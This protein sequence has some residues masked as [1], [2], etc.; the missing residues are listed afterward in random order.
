MKRNK[1]NGN[2]I[3]ANAVPIH[4]TIYPSIHPSLIKL[5]IHNITRMIWNEERSIAVMFVVK[6]D[7]KQGYQEERKRKKVHIEKHVA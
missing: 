6:S 7:A 4:N 5:S 3:V 2:G 1:E